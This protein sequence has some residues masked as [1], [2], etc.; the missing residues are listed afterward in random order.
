MHEPETVTVAYTM[1]E[2]ETVAVGYT[3][4]EPE[5][6]TVAYTMH[7]LYTYID[8][9]HTSDCRTFGSIGGGGGA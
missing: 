9:H 6:V 2:L 8:T 1:H 3:M 4:H 5:T 7:E